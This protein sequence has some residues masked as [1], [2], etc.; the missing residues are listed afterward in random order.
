V[1]DLTGAEGI[2][3]LS[4]IEQMRFNGQNYTIVTSNSTNATI[5]GGSGGSDGRQDILLGFNGTDI[6]N[7]N[8]GNDILVGGTGND[9]IRGGAADDLITWRAGDGRDIING[10][11]VA[12]NIAG[13]TD[14][15]YISGD[16]TVETFNLYTRAAWLAIS[17][18]LAS[19]INADTEIVITRNGANS[20]AI[21]TELNNVEEITIN[22]MGGGDHFN[23]SG[24]FTGTSLAYSTITLQGDLGDD[25]VDISKLTSEHRI[26]FHG[27]GGND[28]V[29][30]D[31]RPQDM[32]DNAAYTSA[33][34]PASSDPG[35]QSPGNG[36]DDDTDQ[37]GDTPAIDPPPVMPPYLGPEVRPG[38]PADDVLIGGAG[39]DVVSGVGGDDVMLGNDG[40]DTLKGGD[41]DDLIKGGF[42]DD[43]AMGNTGND[44][45]FGGAGQDMLFGDQGNDRLFGDDGNDVIEGGAGND[46]VYAGAGD[47][48][49][50]ATINDGDDIYWGDDGRDTVDYSAYTAG[51]KVDLGNGLLQ[52]GSVAS[53]QGGNDT[54]FGFENFIGGSGNDTIVASAAVNVMDGGPGNDTY[55]FKSTGDANGDVIKGLEPGDRIDLSGVDANTGS[56]GNQSF[57]LFA[58]TGFTAAGQLLVTHEMQDGVEHTIVAGNTNNDTVADFKIDVVGNHALTPTDFHGVN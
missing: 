38:T 3:T 21:I 32:V 19:Q 22:G 41:G 16:G 47:D 12:A 30:G 51:V 27:G 23:V 46:T 37:S 24:D 34:P 14:R 50:L 48:R 49:V 43:V 18:N 7:G 36:E 6:L 31:V 35:S 58:G 42:G 55:V 9:T 53:T 26:V 33:L 52:H 10:D 1:S 45:V 28:M 2:D 39:D 20:A 57:V 56:G 54:I 15:M 4:S 5:N 44:D 40:A 13:T 11:S 8:G 25:T 29:V 17:G